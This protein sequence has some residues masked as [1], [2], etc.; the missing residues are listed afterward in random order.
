PA[1]LPEGGKE[2]VIRLPP[3]TRVE[4]E[5]DIEGGEEEAS[6]FLQLVMHE[7]ETW[8]GVE[9]MR[10]MPIKNQGHIELTSLPPGR[11]Q[12]ARSRSLRH[13]NIGQGVFLDR[14][15]VEVASD[16]TTP[17]SFVR[18]TGARLTGSV[19]WDEGT[20]LTGVILS[21]RKAASPD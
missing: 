5:Y 13:G 15:F 7:V 21:V 3:P 14:Q 19:E 4:I 17:V 9:I 2:T 1:P 16:E 18:T 11:Y 8:K 20:K 12:F 10:Q 6:V